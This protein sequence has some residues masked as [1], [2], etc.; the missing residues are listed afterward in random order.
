MTETFSFISSGSEMTEQFAESLGKKLQGGEVFFLAGDVGAGK[1][2]FT[3]G[4]VRGAQSSDHVSSPTFTISNIYKTPQFSIHHFD[5]YR[6]PDAGILQ[7]EIQELLED[8]H[9]ILI[10]E[11]GQIVEHV[12]TK[13]HLVLEF[14]QTAE[15]ERE[16]IATYPASYDYLFKD[17]A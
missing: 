13:K 9:N 7:H 6:L 5:F 14:L 15:D 17:M 11:W 16:I 3:R 2:T 4:F 10:I 12:I 8:D 1:T